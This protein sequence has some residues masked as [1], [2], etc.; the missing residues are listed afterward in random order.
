M[1]PIM[2]GLHSRKPQDYSPFN[3]RPFQMLHLAV[4]R[5]E[6]YLVAIKRMTDPCR[7]GCE[8]YWIGGFFTREDNERFHLYVLHKVASVGHCHRQ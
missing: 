4:S 5:E 7:I 8:L 3:R 6:C 1:I 2:G